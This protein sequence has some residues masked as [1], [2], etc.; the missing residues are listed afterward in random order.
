MLL[1]EANEITIKHNYDKFSASN[2]WLQRFSTHYQI[3]F[4]N[5]HGESAEVSEDATQQWKEK[6]P[7][8]CAGYHPRD[9]YNCNETDL[10]LSALPQKSLISNRAEHSGVKVS[11]DR[12]SVLMCTNTLGEKIQLWII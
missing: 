10:F 4:A 12:F 9:I 11:R 3:K 7:K 5:L 8:I 6:L 2:G 1:V